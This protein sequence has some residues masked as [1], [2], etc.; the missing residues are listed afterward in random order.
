MRQKEIKSM[1][2]VKPVI[3]NKTVKKY[4]K[5][6][7]GSGSSRPYSPYT[8]LTNV[9]VTTKDARS[10]GTVKFNISGTLPD[11]R[12]IQTE[13]FLYKKGRSPWKFSGAGLAPLE[14][15]GGM[16]SHCQDAVH[17]MF[18]PGEWDRSYR[19]KFPETL[20]T[21]TWSAKQTWQEW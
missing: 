1:T 4:D 17:F 8:L 7:F 10:T 19:Y 5:V 11:G 15:S 20:V 13:G 12:T 16:L 14:Y 9:T 18:E 3:A 6:L 2:F 21:D